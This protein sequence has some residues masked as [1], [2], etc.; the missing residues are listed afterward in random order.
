[1][2]VDLLIE[3][4]F[5]TFEMTQYTPST[6]STDFDRLNSIQGIHRTELSGGLSSMTI[7]FELA[8]SRAIG[9]LEGLSMESP[10]VCD[11]FEGIDLQVDILS[12]WLMG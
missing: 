8:L 9:T 7:D 6:T 5:L 1:L 2:K 12:L 3:R 10:S 11:Y 4:P